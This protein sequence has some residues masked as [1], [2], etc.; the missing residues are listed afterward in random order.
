[1]RTPLMTVV[2][3]LFYFDAFAWS[4]GVV[5]RCTTR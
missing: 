4:I 1:M 3:I 5:P 2:T